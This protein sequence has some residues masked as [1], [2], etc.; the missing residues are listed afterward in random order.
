MA[1]LDL[2]E[3][4]DPDGVRQ[5]VLSR[6]WFHTIDLGHGVVTPG[7]DASAEKLG[8]IGLPERL[9]GTSVLD[10][11]A[12]DGFFAFEAERRGAARVVAADEFCWSHPESPLLDGRGFDIARW[13]LSSSVEKVVVSVEDLTP[14][15]VGGRFDYVLFLGV[16]YHAPDPMRYLRNVAEVCAGTLILETHVDA[17]DQDRPMMVFYPGGTLGGDPSNFWGPNPACVQAMLEE[18]GFTGVRIV[19]SVGSRVTFHARRDAP[20]DPFGAA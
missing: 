8:L 7:I 12:F 15:A 11:G 13:A 18:V 14:A 5:L 19:S 20:R 17:V 10:V 9:D 3:T 1:T 2:P 6:P 16:L 4:V